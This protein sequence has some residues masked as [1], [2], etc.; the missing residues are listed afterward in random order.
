MLL[1]EISF[2]E[3]LQAYR[4]LSRDVKEAQFAGQNKRIS[5]SLELE[6]IARFCPTCCKRSIGTKLVWV[7][8]HV[9]HLRASSH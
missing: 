4:P 1:N 3:I 7:R 6:T 5:I 9:Q 2:E 8:T